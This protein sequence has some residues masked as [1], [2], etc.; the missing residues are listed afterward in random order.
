M[1][2]ANLLKIDI[3]QILIFFLV[4][5]KTW[6]DNF[7]SGAAPSHIAGAGRKMPSEK[8]G[9][10]RKKPPMVCHLDMV[11]I[12]VCTAKRDADV[13]SANP[14]C[15]QLPLIVLR[16]R[17]SIGCEAKGQKKKGCKNGPLDWP[18]R[19]GGWRRLT[20]C[21][22]QIVFSSSSFLALAGLR[23]AFTVRDS[24]IEIWTC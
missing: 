6:A 17:F 22:H 9:L 23:L 19:Y 5:T 10:G 12:S 11:Q 24:E 15:C 7:R 1:Y 2:L 21:W 13:T 4:H 18:R 14:G 8:A 3:L 16:A 20:G